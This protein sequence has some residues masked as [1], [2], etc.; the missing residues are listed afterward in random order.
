[1]KGKWFLFAGTVILLAVAAGALSVLR[2]EQ[3][4]APKVAAA[5][6]ERTVTQVSLTGRIQAHTVVQV[7]VPVLGQIE[8]FHADVGSDVYEGQ[9][10]AQIRNQSAQSEQQAA[11]LEIER[12]QNRVHTLESEIAASRLE[13]SRAMADATRARGE[14]DR[15]SRNYER[16]KMLMAE[17]ATPR[18]VYEKSE[19]DYKAIETESKTLDEVAR[20]ADERVST[21]Q[22]ELDNARRLLDGKTEDLEQAAAKVGAGNIYAP[23]TGTI[24]GRRG[25]PGDDV[26]PGITDLFQIATDLSTLEVVVEPSPEILAHIQTGQQ[27]SITIAE[28]ANESLPGVVKN[29]EQGRVHVE[30]PNPD[31]LIKPGLTAQVTF[32]LT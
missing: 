27:V 26:N 23:V 16:Q 25:E 2:R 1:M 3:P 29:V 21:L 24:S 8:A 10:L 11:T 19:R 14:L 4:P 32:K 9:L 30:F 17:G 31:P 28:M 7:P 20:H 18:L 12:A 22:R 5:P 15:A 13:A 6:P